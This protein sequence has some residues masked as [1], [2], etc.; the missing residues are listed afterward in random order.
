MNLQKSDNFKTEAELLALTS[1]LTRKQ[2]ASD[3]E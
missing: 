3:L 2:I 1:R